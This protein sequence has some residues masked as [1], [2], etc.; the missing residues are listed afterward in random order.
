MAESHKF[1]DLDSAVA[2]FPELPWK[3]SASG[4]VWVFDAKADEY[5]EVTKGDYIVSIGNRFEVS[6]SEPEKAKKA[7][8]PKTVESRKSDETPESDQP[9]AHESE[10]IESG[11]ATRT[12]EEIQ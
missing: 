12:S 11:A 4:K 8:A 7:E 3:T 5:A 10:S 9:N 1:K 2:V 6:D